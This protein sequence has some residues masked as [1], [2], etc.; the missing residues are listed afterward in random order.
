MMGLAVVSFAGNPKAGKAEPSTATTKTTT[1]VLKWFHFTGDASNPSELSD[2]S[3][4]EEE[5]TPTCPSA[6]NTYRCD[7]QI[8]N[9]E[10]NPDQPDLSQPVQ[11][12][13][14]RATAQD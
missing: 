7:I 2:P 11:D 4:Y 8:L 10:N 14:R 1:A 6:D 13:R 3:L 12:I 9:D 5:T